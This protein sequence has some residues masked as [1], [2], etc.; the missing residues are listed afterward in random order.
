MLNS[1]KAKM[2]VIIGILV[3]ILIAGS[4]IILYNQ[5]SRI[6]QE[7]IFDSA[8][9]S[10]RQNAMIITEWLDGT[11]SELSSLANTTN[12]RTMEWSR[13][14]PVLN[15]TLQ[16]HGDYEMMYVIDTK[17]MA[18]YSTG[19]TGNL[20]DRD[21]FQDVM[22]TGK[23]VISKPIISRATGARIISIA[24]PI[25]DNSRRNI[26]GIVAIAVQLNYLQDLVGNMKINGSGYGWIIDDEMTTIAHPTER[27]LGNKDV[28]DDGNQELKNIALHMSQ[29]ETGVEAYRLNG[30]NKM[31]AF[32]PI[33]LSGWSI[34]M[35]ADIDEVLAELINIRNASL[36]IGIIGLLIGIVITYFIAKYIADP[37]NVVTEHAGIIAKGDFTR[38]VPEKYLSRNDEI[39]TLGKSFKNM[40][41]NLRNMINQVREIADQVAASSEELSASGEQIGEAAEE[42]SSAIQVVASGAEE[43][44][45]QIDETRD[46][47]SSLI[48]QISDV[49]ETSNI[50][51]ES[52]DDVM[53]SIQGGNNSL[54]MS[55]KKVNNVKQDSITVAKTVNSLGKLSEEIGNI[56]DLIN[57]ISEQTNL[58]ALNAAIEAARAGEAGRGFSVVAEEIRDLAEESSTA[59]NKIDRLIKEIQQS[60]N[61]A[62]R[63][64]EGNV[65]VVDESVTAIEETGESFDQINAAIEKLLKLISNV[66]SRAQEMAANSSEVNDAV[67]QISFVSQEAAGNAEEVAASSEEQNAATEEIISAS[68]ELAKMAGELSE[69]VNR[70]KI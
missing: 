32:A 44:S 5:A 11:I 45:A 69:T 33:E 2:I 17:G 49:G 63:K 40:T 12:L 54:S 43:Q 10:A 61:N 27:Y 25:F 64:M 52:A 62:V 3:L 60:V 34:S 59:T 46:N 13:Q 6:M 28:L 9:N 65:S 41:V 55:I 20:S 36:W 30:V 19:G 4:S 57:G 21:Y 70:F 56:I 53:N 51:N 68:N 37:I 38:D 23:A 26:I 29:G 67:K 58:L 18:N 50:M 66:S 22:Q 31:L 8:I 1:I 14:L 7:S 24:Q 35:A 16:A 48:K 39:G 42:V 47:L 15:E